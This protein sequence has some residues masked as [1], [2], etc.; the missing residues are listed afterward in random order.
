MIEACHFFQSTW[1]AKCFIGL[2]IWMAWNRFIRSVFIQNPSR[3]KHVYSIEFEQQI[4]TCVQYRASA[5]QQY[6]INRSSNCWLII[7][8]WKYPYCWDVTAAMTCYTV[9]H[10]AYLHHHLITHLKHC[11]TCHIQMNGTTMSNWRRWQIF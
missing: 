3:I 11:V 9:F 4:F 7:I 10:Y 5:F 2:C 6:R 8:N 1:F